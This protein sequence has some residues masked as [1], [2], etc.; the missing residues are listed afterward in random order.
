MTHKQHMLATLKG[1][2]TSRIPWAPRLDLWYNANKIAGTL[3]EKYRNAELMEITD[4][5]NFGF[6]A[7]IPN[8]RDLKTPE[9]DI[10]RGL[11][12]YNTHTK[13]IKTIFENVKRTVTTEGDKTTVEYQTPV[14]NI[15]T[16]V[17]YNK[18][19]RKAGIT[20]TH[21]AEHAIKSADDYKV[22][23]YI[24]EN[25]KVEKNYDSYNQWASTIGQRGFA[26]GFVSLAASPMN[27]IQRELIKM[28][29]F[30]Y[31]MNDYPDEVNL[32][33]D[34]I[35][36]YW[37]KIFD[38]ASSCPAE[39][40][41]LG[42]NYDS[43]ITYPPFFAK[44]ILPWL[45]K[46]AD[47]WHKKGKFLLT[48]TDGENTG[49]LEHYLAAKIDIADSVCPAPMTKLTFKEV[50]DCFDGRISIMGG[51][52]SI[53]MLED[54]MAETDFDRFLDNFFEDIGSGDHLIL[55]IS[56]TTPPAAKFERILKIAKRI[57]EFGPVTVPD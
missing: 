31:H 28:D 12:V 8:F 27:L 49:L 36:K 4:D 50:R 37:D 42:S 52:P 44:H 35:G 17:L 38:V 56:D 43:S 20:I 45:K 48:H 10:D 16:V 9:D 32:L 7:V 57:E 39:V 13:P 25:A 40:L 15:Q 6:H 24:F 2:N 23:A 30:F 19:M 34:S 3:P 47:K 22:L 54:S 1:A 55:G 53:A 33:A 21:I 11:G 18:A 41:L 51:I 5:L 46:A 26:V 29:E 14:G